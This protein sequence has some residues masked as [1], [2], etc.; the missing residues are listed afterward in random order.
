MLQRVQIYFLYNP[1]PSKLLKSALQ[2]DFPYENILYCSFF[3][4]STAYQVDEKLIVETYHS[5]GDGRT[6]VDSS[7]KSLAQSPTAGKKK[8]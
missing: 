1:P 8:N 6:T 7:S 5:V 3:K 2:S 4:S